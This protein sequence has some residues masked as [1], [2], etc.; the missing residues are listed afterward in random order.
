MTSAAADVVVVGAGIVGLSVA[1]Q[2]ARR[3]SLRV[4][5][6]E[7][8]AGPGEGSTGAS[9]ALIRQ[10]YT[11]DEVIRLA[12]HALVA[13]RSWPEFTRLAEPAGRF[14]GIGTLWMLGHSPA[15][16]AADRD[17]LRRH[18]ADAHVLDAAAVRERFPALSTCGAPFDLTGEVEHECADHD[19]FLF[20]ADAGYFTPV[21]ACHDLV[22][23]CRREGVELRFR[24]PVTGIRFA[25][26]AVRGV[27]LAGGDI[28]D[29]DVVVNAAGPWCNALHAMA[30]VDLGWDLV[31]TRIQ[32]IRRDLPP[33]LLPLPFV[34]DAA[35]GTYFRPEAG[36]T[37][38]WAGSVRAEDEMEAVDPDDFAATADRAYVDGKIHGV[39]HRLPGLPHRGQLSGFAG[40]YTVNRDDV[41]PIIGPTPLA[42]Y[43]VA[44]GFSGHG[45]KEAPMVGAML[46]R[47]ITGEEADFD[48]DVPIGFFGIDR[49]PLPV[50]A[51]T[52]LA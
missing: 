6:V 3:S 2:V 16:A 13:Y 11:H 33:E 25:G 39:H 15:T 8:A 21:L 23:A 51:K 24:S 50:A 19:A 46:A 4:V 27:A 18:G 47:W 17:R 41:H 40:L 9:V 45:F 42:G 29:G 7:R 10:R 38:L 49:A 14:H 30:G 43:L 32:V 48:T 26:D 28:I 31:P 20:E 35:S 5:V 44:N 34:F 12:H 37:Q 52:V 36:G 1:Y 22:T